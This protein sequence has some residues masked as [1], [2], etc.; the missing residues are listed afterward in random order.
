MAAQIIVTERL[1]LR[2]WKEEDA[3]P[4]AALNADP[5]VREYFPSILTREQSDA[6]IGRIRAGYERDGFC[7]YA[8]E[9]RATGELIGFIGLQTIG[10]AIPSV[11][12]PTVET[13]W[14]LAHAHWGKGLATEGARA[15]LQYGLDTLK[16]PEII[17]ITL[18]GNVRSRRVMEKI[19]LKHFPELDFEHPRLPEGHPMRRHV[20]YAIQNKRANARER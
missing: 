18:P 13:G 3:A 1:I 2:T 7:M 8:A 17:A 9:L 5:R 16:L 20:L 6:E 14:R 19:G 12:Q 10:Y 15:A 4:Y 11:A